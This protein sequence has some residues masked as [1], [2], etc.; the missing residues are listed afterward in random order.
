VLPETR[1][2]DLSESRV[3]VLNDVLII[4]VDEVVGV[5]HVVIGRKLGGADHGI[6]DA[7]SV[8]VLEVCLKTRGILNITPHLPLAF[9]IESAKPRQRMP[10]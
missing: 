4:E 1:A 9:D 5:G 10:E 2:F 3:L 7:E 6:I 8:D